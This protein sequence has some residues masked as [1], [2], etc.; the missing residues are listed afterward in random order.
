MMK[1]SKTHIKQIIKEEIESFEQTNDIDV[2]LASL[3]Q[4]M[5]EMKQEDPRAY[6]DWL[7]KLTYLKEDIEKDLRQAKRW[8]TFEK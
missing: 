5:I 8:N 1:L 2:I 6:K 3:K 4:S 7:N